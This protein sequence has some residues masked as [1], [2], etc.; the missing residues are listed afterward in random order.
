MVMGKRG[1]TVIKGGVFIY[2]FPYPALSLSS[3]LPFLPI[4]LRSLTPSPLL[5]FGLIYLAPCSSFQSKAAVLLLALIEMGKPL[6][7]ED[8][9][10]IPTVP[11]EDGRN[12]QS[13]REGGGQNVSPEE[14][15]T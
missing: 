4:V 12:L 7:D 3:P 10:D 11:L 9:E 8:G 14:A 15:T 1:S 5:P 13:V 6:R 2:K